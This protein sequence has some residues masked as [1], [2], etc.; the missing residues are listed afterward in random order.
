[1]S[2]LPTFDLR[3]VPFSRRG[4]WMNLSP[5]VAAHAMAEEVHLVSHRTGMHAVLSVVPFSPRCSKCMAVAEADASCLRWSDGTS[6]VRAV[7]AAPDTVRIRGDAG[8]ALRLT[9]AAAELTPFTGTYLFRD[10]RD[11]SAVFTSYETGCR[12]RVTPVAGTI[13]V[14]GLEALG[15]APRRITITAGERDTAWEIV[16]EEYDTSR[17]PYVATSSF[18]AC[19]KSV[20]EEFRA[21]TRAVAPWVGEH[22]CPPARREASL[23]ATYVL[24]SATVA[25][26]GFLQREAVLMSKHW[27][28]KVWSWDHCFNAIALAP[29]LPSLALDQFLAPFDH[30]DTTGALP[31]SIAHSER[32]YNFV[33]PPIHGWALARL[34]GDGVDLTAT[35]LRDVYDKLAR[36][37]HFWL[38]ERRTDG[39]ALPYYQHGNDSGWDNATTFDRNRMIVSPDLA[40]FLLVQLEVLAGIAIELG[41]DP[42]LWHVEADRVAKGL[43]ELRRDG[44]FVAR[45]ATDGEEATRTSLLPSLAIVAGDRLPLDDRETL[46]RS[47]LPFLTRWGPATE[48]PDSQHYA[49]DGYW[50][51]P[52]WAPSTMLI[53]DGL[54]RAGYASL[55]DDIST[56]FQKLC[57]ASGFAENF[58]AQ[59]GEGL[60]DRA[61]TWTAA[62]YLT[63][64]RDARPS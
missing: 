61:Y 9:D 48:R 54:R 35:Q 20:A 56:R 18:D 10:P 52:I 55:A 37:T 24:W 3:E 11:D 30:Q 44:T 27:M 29:G 34:R 15:A 46:A 5:V 13:H 39:H 26:A 60:R 43:A 8:T 50:R 45:G 25:P 57:E 41:E 2:F 6:S 14:E 49:D 21:F 64:V 17:A 23:L 22:D 32:L 7:F 28:D 40:A 51:G 53:E 31:D 12:Y 1:M 38:S 19:Q 47:V 58:D 4:S 36:W 62:V 16:I 33:K 42:S 59:T 63:L